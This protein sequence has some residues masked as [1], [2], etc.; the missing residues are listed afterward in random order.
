[1]FSSLFPTLS[2]SLNQK[3]CTEDKMALLETIVN[4]SLRGKTYKQCLRFCMN[5]FSCAAFKVTRNQNTSLCLH[6]S[7][8]WR[9][10]MAW[11]SYLCK[12]QMQANEKRIITMNRSRVFI[13]ICFKHLFSHKTA[14]P[15]SCEVVCARSA[16]M[17]LVVDWL[18]SIIYFFI[19]AIMFYILIPLS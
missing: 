12:Q 15:P 7:V 3:S 4:P 2:L 6:D 10:Y 18:F 1:M 9:G 11:N 16:C 13:Y 14:P 5:I 19:V 8:L 17:K